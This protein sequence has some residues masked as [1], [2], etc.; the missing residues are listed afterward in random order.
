VR[1]LAPGDHVVMSYPWCGTCENCAQD[2]HCYCVHG[3]PLKMNGTRADGSTLLSKNGAPVYS[4]F[5]QQSSFGTFALT[6]ERYTVKVR[7]DAPLELLGPLA[8][9]GQTGA[10]AVFNVMKPRAGESLA[11]FGVGAVGLSALMAAKIAGCDPIIAVDIRAQR[12]ALARE[13][14]ATH[15]IDH[16]AGADVVAAIRAIGGGGVRYSL[17]TSALPA[18]FREAVESLKPGGTCVLLGSARGGTEVPID[19]K[20]LQEGRVVRGVIQGDSTPKD[21][22]PRL[23]D[24]IMDGKFPIKKMIKFYDFADINRAAEESSAGIAIKPVLRMPQ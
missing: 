8:C 19:M 24:L 3:F 11:V 7:N 20:F 21:F 10:G 1:S 12:L 23:V 22:I 17:D 6:Q 5:F 14:G 16:G 2:L 9:S 4:A 15:T 18:V 13:L